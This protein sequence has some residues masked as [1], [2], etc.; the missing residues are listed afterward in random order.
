MVK[1][2]NPWHLKIGKRVIQE[3]YGWGRVTKVE[4]KAGIAQI[5]I[6]F[7]SNETERA[8]NMETVR[9]LA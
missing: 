6:K 2:A 1:I 4:N 8:F 5:I 7:D 9:I 3:K